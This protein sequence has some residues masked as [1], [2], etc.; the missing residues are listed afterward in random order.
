[1][2]SAYILITCELGHED[3]TVNDLN[4]LTGVNATRLA[5]AYDIIA[6]VTAESL[7]ELIGLDVKEMRKYSQCCLDLAGSIVT[8]NWLGT[9]KK[10][11]E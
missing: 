1:M 7:T 11:Q 10:T 4:K 6:K 3:Q 9:Y 2:P 8:M 5:G